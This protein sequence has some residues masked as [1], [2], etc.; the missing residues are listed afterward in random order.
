MNIASTA[1]S[2]ADFL[3]ALRIENRKVD[4]LPQ[5]HLPANL[6]D[7]YRAQDLLVRRL[8]NHWGGDTAGYKIALTN[9]AAQSMLGVPHPVFGQILSARLHQDGATLTAGDYIVR[10][11]ECEFGFRMARNV[12]SSKTP[13]T[14]DRIADYVAAVLPAIELVEFHF[15]RIDRVTPESLAAD[16]AIHGAWIHGEECTDWRHIDLASQPT[17][18]EVNGK[19]ELLGS[20]NRV[21]GHPLNALAWLANTLPEHG[22]NL[23]A[24][25]YVTTGVTTDEIYPASAG[26]ELKAVFGEVGSVQLSFQ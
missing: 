10:M 26:D 24:G 25:E 5:S 22:R 19:T 3:A 14:A 20:G 15:A 6:A 9:P 16:N 2:T 12:P 1:E 18:L 8:L 13:Y 11:I 17:A 4:E 7:A 21:L 23:R